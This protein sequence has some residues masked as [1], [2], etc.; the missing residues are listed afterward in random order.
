M[1]PFNIL[2]AANKLPTPP[3]VALR[4]LQLIE[5]EH[6]SLEDLTQVI[7]SDPALTS[8]IL[9]FLSSP[10]VGLGFHGSTLQE[11]VARIGMRG[12]QMLA[13][14]F[15]LISQKHQKACPSFSFDRFWSESL[16]RAVAARCL[17]SHSGG[18][19]PEEAFI[20]G[21]VG[22]IGQ[23][24]FATGWPEKYES[25]LHKASGATSTLDRERSVFGTNH[26][27][28][29]V[30][31]LQEWQ[32]PPVVW[33]TVN[34]LATGEIDPAVEKS[35]RVLLLADTIGTFMVEDERH[36]A[37]ALEQIEEIADKNVG[38]RGEVFRGL[39]GQ[40]GRDWIHYGRL[41]SVQTPEPPDVDAIERQAEEHR[42]ALRLASEI[43]VQDLRSANE[44]LSH[45]AHYDK[46]TGLQNRSA[47]DEL[48]G[49]VLKAA[50]KSEEPLAV[51]LIDADR[52]KSINDAHGHPV[53]DAVLK[54]LARTI[55]D[56][57]RKR[58]KVFRYG[59]EEFAIV[60][61]DGDAATASSLAESLRSAVESAPFKGSGVEI[62]LTVSLGIALARWPE[63]PRTIESM[64]AAA[65]ERLYDAK[66]GGRNTWSISEGIVHQTGF[67]WVSRFR[68]LFH[69]KA[70]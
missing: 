24:V 42:T 15:S 9:K 55:D 4:I 61:L 48:M 16:A 40:I 2:K 20:T 44:Q 34:G 51:I 65:D 23:L 37:D 64:V 26:L 19:D 28:T 66:R 56:N 30:R 53:G 27:E 47:F 67:G 25:V 13:L 22:R 52:F 58:D 18:Q 36:T 41:L 69:R 63:T 50:E 17:A 11:A 57:V 68:Q 6:T 31:L 10:L 35:T 32:L 39:I 49:T 7:G 70:G 8:K 33:K 14:S 12:A 1:D 45:I 29:S 54:H 43:E 62:S 46:L 21:L 3:S 5:S 38:I 60:V 59:G